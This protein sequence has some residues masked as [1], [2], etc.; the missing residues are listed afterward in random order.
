M[1]PVVKQPE[2]LC[3]KTTTREY[4]TYK[5]KTLQIATMLWM[6]HMCSRTC[7]AGTC[8]CAI[9]DNS[10]EIWVWGG[11][12]GGGGCVQCQIQAYILATCRQQLASSSLL[13]GSSDKNYVNTKSVIAQL[14]IGLPWGSDS[15]IM[16]AP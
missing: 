8:R 5:I 3:K 4:S 10:S 16:V 15:V 14:V 2:G 12:G 11:G 6:M 7:H 9:M 1:S 13:Y